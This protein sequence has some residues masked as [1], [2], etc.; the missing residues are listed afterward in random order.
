MR[1][2]TAIKTRRTAAMQAHALGHGSFTAY[3]AMVDRLSAGYSRRERPA[4]GP[5]PP[6]VT[7]RRL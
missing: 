2:R 1:H 7:T 4:R 6:G 5:A 3:V